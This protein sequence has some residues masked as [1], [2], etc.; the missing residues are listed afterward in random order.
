MTHVPPIDSNPTANHGPGPGRGRWWLAASLALACGCQLSGTQSAPKLGSADWMS[1]PSTL[2]ANKAEYRKAESLAAIWTDSIASASGVASVRGFGGRLYFYDADGAPTRVDGE[3][4]IYAFD[5][6]EG[7]QK[8]TPDRVYKFTQ[9]DL[10]K[11]FSETQLGPSYS[12]WLPWDRVGGDRKSIALLPV[13]KSIDNQVVKSG[14]SINVLPGKSPPLAPSQADPFRVLGSS[15][16]LA[17]LKRTSPDNVRSDYDVQQASYV[18]SAAAI[19]STEKDRT[20]TIDVPRGMNRRL[21]NDLAIGSVDDVAPGLSSNVSFGSRT[22]SVATG[23][24]LSDSATKVAP[25]S[26]GAVGAPSDGI[27]GPVA[28]PRPVFGAPGAYK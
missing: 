15:S 4:S 20:T 23:P 16:T 6:T 14:Q 1:K 26:A 21:Q 28:R 9:A 27:A 22:P 19:T 11:H 8:T 10:Q 24:S 25:T 3:L 13:F 2:L 12:I 5:D 17:N 18:D 7:D